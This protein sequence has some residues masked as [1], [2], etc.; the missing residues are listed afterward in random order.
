MYVSYTF[1]QQTGS[2]IDVM[3]GALKARGCDVTQVV[4]EFTDPHYS[5]RFA[6][7]PMRLPVLKIVGMLP[8]QRRHKTGE[9]GIPPEAQEGDYDLVVFGSPTWWLTTNMPVRSY[10][11]SPTSGKVLNGKPFAA[12][13]ISV[14]T[15]RTTSRRSVSSERPTAG[16]GPARPTSSP[17]AGR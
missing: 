2:V 13:S 1:T 16:R 11:K 17:P 6:K 15:G 9:I 12:A 7:L 8:A 10:L 3:T 4:I 14:A 5:K